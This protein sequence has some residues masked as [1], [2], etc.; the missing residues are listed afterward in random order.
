MTTLVL[1]GGFLGSGKTTLIIR[2]ASLLRQRGKRVGVILNDQDAG[3]VDTRLAEAAGLPSK[4][5]AGG[6]FCCRFGD[7]L[8]AAD[9]GHKVEVRGPWSVNDNAGIVVDQ[10]HNTLSAGADPRNAA[11]AL[12]W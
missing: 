1:V 12:A 7:L 11:L 8:D 9:Q 10:V 4:E 3:L 6:C 5:V 2:A